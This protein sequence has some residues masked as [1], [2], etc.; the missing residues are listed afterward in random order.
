L[1]DLKDK[2]ILW[3]FPEIVIVKGASNISYS[4][5]NKNNLFSEELNAIQFDLSIL[6]DQADQNGINVLGKPIK[7]E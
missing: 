4:M 2:E 1:T 5:V 7:I 3:E 6:F